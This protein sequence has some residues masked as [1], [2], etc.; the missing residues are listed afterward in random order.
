M[1]QNTLM[2]GFV[3]YINVYLRFYNDNLCYNFIICLK[4]NLNIAISY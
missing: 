4:T 1:K 3:K 2:F